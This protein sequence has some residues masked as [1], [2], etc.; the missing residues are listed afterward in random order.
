MATLD[1]L[2]PI[3][4]PLKKKFSPKNTGF[5]SITWVP[6]FYLSK[7]GF[8]NINLTGSYLTILEDINITYKIVILPTLWKD[9]PTPN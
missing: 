7:N 8:L 9:S 3:K 1:H 2:N 4:F 6:K 5:A